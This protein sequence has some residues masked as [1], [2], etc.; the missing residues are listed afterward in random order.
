MYGL[1]AC[2]A[3]VLGLLA[4][5]APAVAARDFA[6][7]RDAGAVLREGAVVVDT[8]PVETCRELSLAGARCLPAEGFLGPNH[9]LLSERDLLWLLGTAGLSGDETVLV[10]G[11]DPAARDFVAALLYVAGQSRVR[12]LT[13]PMA[14]LLES[15]AAAAPGRER[16]FTRETV[17]AAP[18]RDGLV[19]LREELRAMRPP[20][21]LLDGRPESEYWGATVRAARSPARRHQPARAAA[22]RFPGSRGRG[23]TRAPGRPAGGLRA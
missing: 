15:G 2:I 12:V 5:C 10:V 7:L 14:R 13:E 19:V 4:A 6:Y 8:R 17:F 20:P 22:A 21:A 18:M 23:Q 9:G 1:R 11:Q 3:T 16:G